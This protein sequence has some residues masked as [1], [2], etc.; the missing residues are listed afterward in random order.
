[1]DPEFQYKIFDYYLQ[2]EVNDEAKVWLTLILQVPATD[3]KKYQILL[4]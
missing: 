2:H 3:L 1:M 4:S